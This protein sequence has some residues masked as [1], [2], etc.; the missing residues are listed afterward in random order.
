MSEL[1]VLKVSER[2]EFGKNPNRRMRAQGD[3]PAVFYDQKG[4]NVAVQVS[5][6]ALERI[7]RHVGRSTVFTLEIDL[8][9]KTESYPA[10]VWRVKHDPVKGT[11]QHLDFFGVDL[12]KPIKVRV[13]LKLAGKAKG[14]AKGGKLEVYREFAD[15]QAKPLEIPKAL[16]L[17]VTSMDVGATVKLSG[18]P[19][20]EGVELLYVQDSAVVTVIA[21]GAASEDE[22]EA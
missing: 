8:A 10:L 6:N 11:P 15:I 17:D 13:P 22:E 7:Y 18:V 16:I 9:G 4:H 20:P 3:I 19:T 21:K 2:T 5:A 12:E 1:K 14:V